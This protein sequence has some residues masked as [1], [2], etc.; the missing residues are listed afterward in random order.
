MVKRVHQNDSTMDISASQLVPDPPRRPA[1]PPNL[2]NDA[3][4]WKQ[5]VVGTDDFAPPAPA[6]RSRRTPLL[7][8]VA[9]AIVGGGAYAGYTL[10][11][12]DDS[13]T[14]ASGA[15]SHD[16]AKSATPSGATTSTTTAPAGS[17]DTATGSATDPTTAGSAT[18]SGS[19]TDPTAARAGS[20]AD[21][22]AATPAVAAATTLEADAISGVAP[23]IKP[24]KKK[25]IR[26]V[27][28]KPTKKPVAKR[29]PAKQPKR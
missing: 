14:T 2:G 3:S 13:S 17:A 4:V 23:V 10:V 9:L 24:K 15:H 1:P 6:K 22:T 5:V 21:P 29:A 26:R 28:K 12:K 25:P 16:H 18:N 7:I 11:A 20:A 19:A 8:A 27:A